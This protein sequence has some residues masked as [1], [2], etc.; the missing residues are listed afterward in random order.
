MNDL[1]GMTRVMALME[2]HNRHELT[3]ECDEPECML[4]R[5]Q[6]YASVGENAK[7][8]EHFLKVLSMDIGNDMRIAA[9]KAYAQFLFSINDFV[10]SA[11]PEL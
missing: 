10:S 5:A 1:D 4:E 2:E 9:Y 3:K 8:R 11:E 6:Y 7:A